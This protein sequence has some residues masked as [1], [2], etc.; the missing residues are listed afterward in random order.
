MNL[1]SR[2]GS[3]VCTILTRFLIN[4]S[5]SCPKIALMRLSDS[6]KRT[7]MWRNWPLG[8]NSFFCYTLKPQAKTVCEKLR[9]DFPAISLFGITWEF[10][11][12]LD[13]LFRMQTKEE[14]IKYLKNCF[15]SFSPFAKTSPQ[16][17]NLTSKMLCIHWIHP[18]S[19]SVFPCLTGQ[20]LEEEKELWKF[21][22]C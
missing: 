16:R 11:P 19:V 18:L 21:I 15:T 2:N 4:C 5:T 14:I 3:F 10:L 1:N 8:I 9:P 12:S 7:G 20:S 6:I 17:K 22:P 13:Q